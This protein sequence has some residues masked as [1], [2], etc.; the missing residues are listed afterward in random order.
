MRRVRGSQFIKLCQSCWNKANRSNWKWILKMCT[1]YFCRNCT[2]INIY[3][4]MD[5]VTNTELYNIKANDV[6]SKDVSS[7]KIYLALNSNQN[8][9]KWLAGVSKKKKEIK[10]KKKKD[11][12]KVAMLTVNTDLLGRLKNCQLDTVKHFTRQKWP[13][14][15]GWW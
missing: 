4:A 5:K 1:P 9:Q 7:T 6:L 11:I 3:T 10:G 13:R 8:V 2:S 15:P 12:N 14:C